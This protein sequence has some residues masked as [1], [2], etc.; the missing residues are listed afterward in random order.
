MLKQS[1][2]IA[3]A[4]CSLLAPSVTA[5]DRL[6]EA[7]QI[8]VEPVTLNNPPLPE[9][10]LE[11]DSLSNRVTCS[12]CSDDENYVLNALQDRGITDKNALAVILGNIRQESKFVTDICEGGRR[13]GYHGCHR[14][15]FG[16]IQFTSTHR[17][18][19]LGR[20][21]RGNQMDPN[22]IETQTQYMFTER[23]WISAER[24]FKREGQ[25]RG[26]YMNYAYRWLGWGVHGSRTHYANQYAG[27]LQ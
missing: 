20:Y 27:K 24:G 13:T 7:L 10:I 9:S 3:L 16:L 4:S 6:N 5:S 18:L 1:A 2:L 26:Y 11:I 25:S 17:Y 15:G 22:H 23:E 19:G 8:P 21:A 12:N 14:G